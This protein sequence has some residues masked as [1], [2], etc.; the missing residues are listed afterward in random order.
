[1]FFL[2]VAVLSAQLHWDFLTTRSPEAMATSQEVSAWYAYIYMVSQ[3]W[4]QCSDSQSNLL[5][6]TWLAWH[7]LRVRYTRCVLHSVFSFISVQNFPERH[8]CILANNKNQFNFRN[9]FLFLLRR[10]ISITIWLSKAQSIFLEKKKIT[11][12]SCCI[13]VIISGCL[14]HTH[15]KIIQFNSGKVVS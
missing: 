2:R 11:V 7:C 13:L 8:I 9:G 1:M 15:K 12:S 14:S 6:Y 5:T 3:I 4:K 10:L